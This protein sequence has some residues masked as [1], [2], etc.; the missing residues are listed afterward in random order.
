MVPQKQILV[1]EDNMINRAM[2][3]EI[4]SGEFRVL[5]AEN[6][7]VALDILKAHKEDISLILLDVMMP[8]MDGYTFL[9]KI[10]DEADLALIP[11]IVMTQ[12]NSDEDEVQAL[13]HGATDFVP[14]P[15]RPQV[16]L[17]RVAS[18]IKLRE[19]AAIV[20]LLQYDR[21]TGLYSKEFFYQKVKERL[22]KDSEKEYTII[23]TNIENFKLYNDNFGVSAGDTLLKEMARL[24]REKS[25]EEAI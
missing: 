19:T 16:I 2:L 10:K 14:K 1:V 7:Q 6:G 13:A 9:D 25:G 4:L 21:L 15:Y 8:V 20:N 5:E 23:S 11:V 12:A 18:I 22:Q 17:H 24:L 3:S